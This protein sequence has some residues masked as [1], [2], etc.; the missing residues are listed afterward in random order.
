MIFSHVD[1]PMA[2]Q[3]THQAFAAYPFKYWRDEAIQFGLCTTFAQNQ[4][5][6]CSASF[7]PD[8]DQHNVGPTNQQ[9]NVVFDLIA[10]AFVIITVSWMQADRF[11]RV[12]QFNSA[13]KLFCD[14]NSEPF[15]PLYD[16][17]TL[18]INILNQM[19]SPDPTSSAEVMLFMRGSRMF[20]V[21]HPKSNVVGN[22]FPTSEVGRVHFDRQGGDQDTS[23]RLGPEPDEQVYLDAPKRWYGERITSFRELAHRY[24][25]YGILS[26]DDGSTNDFKV[27]RKNLGWHP[28]PH[29]SDTIKSAV[30]FSGG[31]LPN[32]NGFMDSTRWANNSTILSYLRPAFQGWNGGIKHLANFY[33]KTSSTNTGPRVIRGTEPFFNASFPHVEK[34][35]LTVRTEGSVTATDHVGMDELF[36][37][38]HTINRE[39][40]YLSYTIPYYSHTLYSATSGMYYF[41]GVPSAN[42][43]D[44]NDGLRENGHAIECR[45]QGDQ[46]WDHY[47]A[48]ADDYNLLYY[49]GPP[50]WYEAK[51]SVV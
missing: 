33:I 14:I 2:V 22:M 17:G 39:V 43:I 30:S 18:E 50:L 32:T 48:G 13:G 49:F 46:Q 16:N 41:P 8:S 27:M 11:L 10:G 25:F 47:V 31:T 28:N 15:D 38:T 20:E 4:R 44:M 36:G 51:L 23:L 37:G 21:A 6:R 12:R 19:V 24:N 26:T 45:T 3:P 29:L 1:G 7:S 42:Q 34:T 35:L 9:Y 5:V 40:G